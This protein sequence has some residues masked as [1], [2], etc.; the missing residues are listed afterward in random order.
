MNVIIDTNGLMIP[1]QFRVD[2]FS[3]LKRLGYDEL[4][5]PQAVINEIGILIKR[6]R[7]ENKTAAK[8]ALSLADRCTIVDRTGSADDVILQLALDTGAAVL[9]N[10]VG[11]I[12][13]LKEVDVTVVR[14]R[15]K[16]HLDIV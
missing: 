2:I 1:V 8:V 13:R 14:L 11:L 16:N 4:I 12:G 10:D 6:Y 5:V 3:E 9:T 15:Q 7:G